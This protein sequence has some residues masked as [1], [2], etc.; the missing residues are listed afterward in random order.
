MIAIES[1]STQS[2]NRGNVF[3]QAFTNNVNENVNV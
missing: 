3:S 2:H 1:N